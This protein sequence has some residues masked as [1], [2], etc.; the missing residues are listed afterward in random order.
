[1]WEWWPHIWWHNTLTQQ[2]SCSNGWLTDNPKDFIHNSL[3]AWRKEKTCYDFLSYCADPLIT[4]ASDPS[5][6]T[7]VG[8]IECT[9]VFASLV[10]Q[11]DLVNAG[12]TLGNL[13]ATRWDWDLFPGDRE[14]PSDALSLCME[15][16]FPYRYRNSNSHEILKI[17]ECSW[18][19]IMV[20]DRKGNEGQAG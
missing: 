9:R 1:M 15:R 4:E 2:G 13:R 5:S 8:Q 18:C 19:I 17:G 14:P 3:V 10:P 11:L 12:I 16:S 7:C 6:V 20:R